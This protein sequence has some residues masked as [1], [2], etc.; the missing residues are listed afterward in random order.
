MSEAR[1]IQTPRGRLGILMPGMGA[2]ATTFIAGVELIK[3]G[4][5]PSLARVTGGGRTAWR[6]RIWRTVV[7]MAPV[8]TPPRPGNMTV[9]PTFGWEEI[10]TV[11][12]LLSVVALGFLL[13]GVAAASLSGRSEWHGYLGARSHRHA[14][15]ADTQQEGVHLHG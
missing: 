2:V 13:L 10:A 14:D 1:D 4:L 6:R 5:V 15:G 3:K 8:P 7:P 9:P 12:A 11:L